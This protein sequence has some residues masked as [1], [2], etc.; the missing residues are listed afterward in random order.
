[1]DFIVTLGN[2]ALE[3]ASEQ[4]GKEL[5]KKGFESNDIKN[6]NNDV[7]NISDLPDS[8]LKSLLKLEGI[9]DVFELELMIKE[10]RIKNE[11]RDKL[12]KLGIDARVTSK[13]SNWVISSKELLKPGVFKIL[14]N[15]IYGNEAYKTITFN[16]MNISNEKSFVKERGWAIHF[17]LK[18]VKEINGSDNY[19]YIMLSEYEFFE[20]K[21][22]M[23]SFNDN[24]ITDFDKTFNKHIIYNDVHDCWIK[25][26]GCLFCKS[27]PILERFNMFKTMLRHG[28]NKNILEIVIDG[29]T[30]EIVSNNF[31][32][33]I[34]IIE[35]L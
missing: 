4:L 33:A 16:Y 17:K 6:N 12:I 27:N 22:K 14:S 13:E 3:G 20:S 10:N 35:D 21:I 1:M 25:I 5:V 32:N 19:F 18:V 7:K 29:N 26:E 11:T 15:K 24:I 31:K 28:V 8:Y 30:I 23:K 34:D 9:D 2:K